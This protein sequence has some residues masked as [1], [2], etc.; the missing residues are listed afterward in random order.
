MKNQKNQKNQ[1]MK[2][3]QVPVH[4]D[5]QQN[6]PVEEPENANDAPPAGVQLPVEG[7]QA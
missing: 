6:E 3:I 1:K 2:Q 4:D 7:T 5:P